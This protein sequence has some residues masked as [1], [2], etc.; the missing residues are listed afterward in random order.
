[1]PTHRKLD[2]YCM[3]CE[4]LY[5]NT[6]RYCCQKCGERLLFHIVLADEI[7]VDVPRNEAIRLLDRLDEIER[8]D[9]EMYLRIMKRRNKK[10]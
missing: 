6:T 10:E 5:M 7:S 4:T 9:R 2:S 3:N 1:M 8:R